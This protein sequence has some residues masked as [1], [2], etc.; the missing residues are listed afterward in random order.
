MA[1]FHFKAKTHFV[2]SSD[3]TT[4]H[5]YEFT[6]P[7]DNPSSIK[8]THLKE[9]A[10]ICSQLV[11][12]SASTST[13]LYSG[14]MFPHSHGR[15]EG[16]EGLTKLAQH[17][18]QVRLMVSPEGY[19][20]QDVTELEMYADLEVYY[21]RLYDR[22]CWS[23]YGIEVTVAA[24]TGWT[25]S[26]L[27]HHMPGGGRGD[28][29]LMSSRRMSSYVRVWRDDY[30]ELKRRVKDQEDEIEDMKD[31]R[32]E[33]R[34]AK[35][36]IVELR[37]DLRD[38]RSEMRSLQDKQSDKVGKLEDEIS[39][40]DREVMKIRKQKDRLEETLQKEEDKVEKLKRDLKEAI[41]KSGTRTEDQQKVIEN[42]DHEIQR[43]QRENADKDKE[44]QRL[45]KEKDDHDEQ[46]KPNKLEL[47]EHEC[48]KY[49]WARLP[50]TK[51][52]EDNPEGK[53]KH[54]MGRWKLSPGT[55]DISMGPT[56][57]HKYY[58]NNVAN[59]QDVGKSTTYYVV[60][61][62]RTEWPLPPPF[63][64]SYIGGGP[65]PPKFDRDNWYACRTTNVDDGGLTMLAYYDGD[66]SSIVL[67]NN[68]VRSPFESKFSSSWSWEQ[69]LVTVNISAVG[70]RLAF[71]W[72]KFI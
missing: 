57:H 47:D 33:L 32:A 25:R 6:E 52:I 9:V 10:N 28:M 37:Q 5:V 8:T 40:K 4:L 45:G 60:D 19:C 16:T 70:V 36:R 13:P 69:K 41:K 14:L 72:R 46:V 62:K 65:E 35:Q 30:E 44:I 39:K 15:I 1:P 21:I 56:A 43:L 50:S 27:K 12:V 11:D 58:Y 34:D 66:M 49:S 61:E 63:I 67:G 24:T 38:K 20:L 29:K 7:N 51:F 2:A 3:G 31:D 26:E 64:L 55:F 42:K 48:P 23:R 68:Y 59:L 17:L 54:L 53:K 71:T 22:F 18:S